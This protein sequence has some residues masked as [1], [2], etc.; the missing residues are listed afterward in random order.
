MS[1]PEPSRD[2]KDWHYILIG[3][4]ASEW[5]FTE[6][7]IELGLWGLIRVT[8]ERGRAITSYLNASTKL[9]LLRKYAAR[10]VDDQVQLDKLK[11]ICTEI[12]ALIEQRNTAVHAVW[13]SIGDAGFAEIQKRGQFRSTIQDMTQ[14]ELEWILTRIYMAQYEIIRWLQ[15]NVPFPTIEEL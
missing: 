2:L 12:N 3:K 14:Q 15:N 9:Q 4:I 11:E 8:Q 7:Q 13:Y 6:L 10:D 1:V 5:A